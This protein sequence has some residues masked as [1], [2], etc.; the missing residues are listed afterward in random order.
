MPKTVVSHWTLLFLDMSG[1]SIARYDGRLFE[2]IWMSEEIGR[3]LPNN[4]DQGWAGKVTTFGN[5]SVG[6]DETVASVICD[7]IESHVVVLGIDHQ[8]VFIVC[9]G[10]RVEEV[11][12]LKQLG[13]WN[14]W[15]GE[16]GD[17]LLHR[18]TILNRN[19]PN[20]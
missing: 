12:K 8:D 6:D 19:D 1:D 14:V 7:E 18:R 17:V 9:C 2:S 4:L 20:Y 15:H 5:P 10:L 11:A 13:Y 16:N 3:N